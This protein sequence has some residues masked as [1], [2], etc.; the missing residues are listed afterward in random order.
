[1]ATTFV[2]FAAFVSPPSIGARPVGEGRP[3]SR[4]DASPSWPAWPT[5]ARARRVTVRPASGACV[6][7][8]G[9][10]EGDK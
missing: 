2:S 5:S 6:Q 3:A 10:V 1:M 4:A 8:L 7:E 9:K